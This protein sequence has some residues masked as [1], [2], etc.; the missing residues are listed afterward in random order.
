MLHLIHYESRPAKESARYALGLLAHTKIHLPSLD[1][2]EKA[3]KS[4]LKRR[5]ATVIDSEIQSRITSINGMFDGV[6]PTDGMPLI[7]NLDFT[8]GGADLWRAIL[9]FE[10][11]SMGRDYY[12]FNCCAIIYRRNAT[13]LIGYDADWVLHD[14]K[15]CEFT[16]IGPLEEIGN[17]RNQWWRK[18][19]HGFRQRCLPLTE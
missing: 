3:I 2:C 6:G 7:G 5:F 10:H 17:W 12:W 8:L 18:I 14:V 16:P 9:N 13:V 4:L 19:P 1:E 11:S 15:V